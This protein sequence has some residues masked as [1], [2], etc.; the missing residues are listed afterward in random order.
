MSLRERLQIAQSPSTRL[1]R[2]GQKPLLSQCLRPNRTANSTRTALEERASEYG[3]SL[4]AR[5]LIRPLSNG[6][7]YFWVSQ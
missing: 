5:V 1:M 6:G 2:N 4:A 7:V 3:R